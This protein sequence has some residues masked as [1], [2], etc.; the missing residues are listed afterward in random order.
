MEDIPMSTRI[1]DLPGPSEIIDDS[2]QN[3]KE[4]PMP[5]LRSQGLQG[6]PVLQLMQQQ[7]QQQAAP[8]KTQEL[9]NTKSYLGYIKDE[10]NEENILLLLVLFLSTVRDYDY[11][12]YKVLGNSVI[13]S[14]LIFNIVK[15]LLLFLVYKLFKF[16]VLPKIRI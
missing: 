1:D 16:Y 14:K 8:E 11:L 3:L 15:V 10:I 9:N 13:E 2:N 7:S 5:Q 12:L 4:T 6:P